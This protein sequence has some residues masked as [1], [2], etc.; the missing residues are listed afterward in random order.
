ME[1]RY[2]ALRFIGT[3]YKVL[4]VIVGIIT[5]LGALGLCGMSVLG[6][7]LLDSALSQSQSNFGGG[8]LSGMVGGV[9]L[10]VVALIYGGGLS[11]TL[12]AAGEGIYLLIALEEN[13]R[14]T[15]LLLQQGAGQP[16]APLV[17]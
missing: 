11:V 1:K 2:S 8:L 5:I 10:S 16:A 17:R 3:I 14:A 6:G 4:G 9:I 12:F 15:A 7:G 13:T